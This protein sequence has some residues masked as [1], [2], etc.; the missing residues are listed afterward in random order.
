MNNEQSLDGAVIARNEAISAGV[1]LQSV[2]LSAA[3]GERLRV[4]IKYVNAPITIRIAGVG[5]VGNELLPSAT[6]VW[7]NGGK[8]Y[9][10]LAAPTE[11]SIYTVSGMLFDK[12]TLPAGDTSIALPK[13]FYIIRTANQQYKIVIN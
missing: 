2:S 3:A 7:A 5:P 9:F 1:D 4:T 6:H 8:A 11:V 12:Q 10:S 13:G